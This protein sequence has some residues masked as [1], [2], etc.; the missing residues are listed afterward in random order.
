M[1]FANNNANPANAMPVWFAPPPGQ[2]LKNITTSASTLVKTGPGTILGLTVNTP[3][4]GATAA[5]Y[6]G[7]DNSGTLLGTFSLAAQGAIALGYSVAVGIF[8]VTTGGTPANITV[9]YL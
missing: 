3:E 4:A 2:T 9:S 5:I 1:A 7:I 8:V 6:D